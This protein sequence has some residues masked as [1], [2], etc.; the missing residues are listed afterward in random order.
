MQENLTLQGGEKMNLQMLR[1]NAGL[2]QAQVA[3]R[4]EVQQS[5]VSRWENGA[6]P[7]LQKYRVHLA[8]LYGCDREMI[9]K[10]VEGSAKRA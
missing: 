9:D 6:N 10:G 8:A 7:P 4:L 3:E 5:A 2:T 1:V